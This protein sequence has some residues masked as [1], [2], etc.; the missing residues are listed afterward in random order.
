MEALKGTGVALVTPFIEDGSIDFTALERIV[1]YTI[2]RGVNYLVVLGTTGEGVTL[3]GSE[4]QEVIQTV[5]RANE[6]RVPLV[7]G[8]GGNST[9]Q[10][11]K[12]L[13]TADLSA[14][15]AV[16]SVSPYYN[17]PSQ[18]GIYRHFKAVAEASSKPVILYN[19]PGRTS[20]NMLPE[21]VKR[22][23]Q[24][25]SNIVA[26]K[27]AKGDIVQ[28]ME[29]LRILPKNFLVISGEDMITLPMVLGGGAG[30]ISVTG[31]A[32][33]QDFTAMVNLAREGKSQQAYDIQYQLMP[34]IDLIFEE[35][36][37]TGIKAVFEYLGLCQSQVRLPLVKAS[38]ELKKKVANF[39][40][41][42]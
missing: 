19:V 32:L 23:A 28:A 14:F 1:H 22:L 13:Q 20:S 18:E 31:Q 15:T 5:I 25:F 17:K 11:V 36:N 33:P 37:P 34:I 41:S 9:A 2:E 39:M 10:V 30:V 16:L 38:S 3:S 42:L 29:L 27:E 6:S 26:I 8:V 12:D 4:K 21:T 35:G 24:D 40:S 7:L